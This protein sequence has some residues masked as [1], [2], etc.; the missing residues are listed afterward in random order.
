[1]LDNLLESY[2]LIT[3]P[4]IGVGLLS[5]IFPLIKANQICVLRMLWQGRSR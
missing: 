1:M 4:P 2:V 3:Q 5:C